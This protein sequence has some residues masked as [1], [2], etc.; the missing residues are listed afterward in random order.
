MPPN[1]DSCASRGGEYASVAFG[2]LA[3]FTIAILFLFLTSLGAQGATNRIDSAFQK[4]WAAKSPEEAEHLIDEIVK[5]GVTFDEAYRRLK[6]GRIYDT[7]K[8]GIVK[9][10]RKNKDGVEHFYAL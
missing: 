9:L 10:S 2:R 6:A 1:L 4:F 3:L 7:Q 8:T 5:S